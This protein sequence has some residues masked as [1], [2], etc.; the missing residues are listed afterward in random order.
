MKKYLIGALVGAIILFCWQSASW[1]FLGVHDKGMKYHPAQSQIMDVLN[2]NTN[3][4]GLYM[5]PS[6][7]TKKEQEAQM[8]EMEGK[9]WASI[10]YHKS[11]SSK[12]PMRIIR[13]F[14]VNFF[15]VISLI[16]IFTRGG[17]PISRR[18]FSGSVALGRMFFLWGP[19]TGHI[20]FDLPWHMIQGDLIDSIVAWS[21][22]GLWLGW[23]LNR[24]SNR[25]LGN[26]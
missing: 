25:A 14:L 13:S 22:C 8:K 1:M 7:P 16:Y 12:M 5:L 20:W 4:D 6:A 23:W 24:P 17:T 26:P 11:W 19:Y 15:L 2:A 9:P 21:L 18:V 10:I 3:E